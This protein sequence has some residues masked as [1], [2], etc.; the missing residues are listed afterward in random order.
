MSDLPAASDLERVKHEVASEAT[1]FVSRFWWAE[2]QKI[3]EQVHDPSA[4]WA[5]LLAGIRQVGWPE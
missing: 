2:G 3:A 1:R 4:R 5:I